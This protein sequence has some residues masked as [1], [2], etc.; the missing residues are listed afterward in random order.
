MRRSEVL[1]LKWGAADLKNNTL[2]IKVAKHT[3][4][5]AKD[6]TKTVAGKRKYA[7]LLEIKEVLLNLKKEAQNNKKL[8]GKE[9]KN[10]GYIFV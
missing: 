6:K 5:V 10:I 7:L 2:E 4:I 3:T 8:F 9:Y 1:G